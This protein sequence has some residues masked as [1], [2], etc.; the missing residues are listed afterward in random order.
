MTNPAEA[1]EVWWRELVRRYDPR[2]RAYARRAQFRGLE[3][4]EIAA[5]VCAMAVEHEGDLRSAGE[6]WDVLV[7]DLRQVCAERM[8]IRRHEIAWSDAAGPPAPTSDE[9]DSSQFEQVWAQVE[10]ALAGLPRRQR[11]IMRWRYWHD[12]SYER[13]AA[14]LGIRAATVRWHHAEGMKELRKSETAEST[15]CWWGQEE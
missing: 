11:D 8:R 7:Q 14:K 12:W 9:R 4:D 3:V 2:M 1:R 6:P 15:A 5:D 13:I 10:R